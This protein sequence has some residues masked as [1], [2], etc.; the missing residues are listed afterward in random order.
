[1]LSGLMVN[2]DSVDTQLSPF[3]E[4]SR[5]CGNFEIKKVFE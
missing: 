5:W 1:M 4:Y 3:D 2:V